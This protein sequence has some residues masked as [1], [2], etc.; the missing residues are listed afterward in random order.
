MQSAT[1]EDVRPL[2]AKLAGAPVYTVY[3]PVGDQTEWLLEF[4][5]STP[6]GG[7]PSPYQVNIG[8]EGVITPPYPISTAIPSNMKNER[9]PTH[10]VLHGSLTANGMLRNVKAIAPGNPLAEI[11]LQLLGEWRFRPATR[12]QKPIDVEVLLIIPPHS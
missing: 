7:G 4:C 5:A 9:I 2:G 1:R 8:E 12:N 6:S 3:L 11:I 10:I